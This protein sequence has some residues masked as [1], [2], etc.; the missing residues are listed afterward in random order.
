MVAA[1]LAHAVTTS[2]GW[3]YVDFVH[4]FA[5]RKLPALKVTGKSGSTTD[6]NVVEASKL[7]WHDYQGEISADL[8]RWTALGWQPTTIIGPE[9]LVMRR[10]SGYRDKN[11]V[12]WIIVIVAAPFTAFMSLIWGLIPAGFVEPLHFVAKLRAPHGT[13]TP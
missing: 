1:S 5:G 2:G 3:D 12:F 7:Y 4:S 10:F 13:P 8:Q 9:A 6:E 11:L